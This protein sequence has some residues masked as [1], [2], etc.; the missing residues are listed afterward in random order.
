MNPRMTGDSVGLASGQQPPRGTITEPSFGLAATE[1]SLGAH[2][3][4]LLWGRGVRLRE[5]KSLA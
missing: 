3:D 1:T 2:S 4:P 5:A